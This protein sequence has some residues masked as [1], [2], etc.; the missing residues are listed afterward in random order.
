M[1]KKKRDKHT[2]K[3]D[4]QGHL[5]ELAKESPN[6]RAREWMHRPAYQTEK[7]S[8]QARLMIRSQGQQMEHKSVDE[9]VAEK[10]IK[11]GK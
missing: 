4:K 2:V 11:R 6:R 10:C 8:Y 5:D 3:N 1:K 9:Y 7:L